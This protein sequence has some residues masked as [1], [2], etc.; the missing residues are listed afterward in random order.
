MYSK[1]ITT[2]STG[3]IWCHSIALSLWF[4]QLFDGR[5]AVSED[6]TFQMIN[7]GF[8]TKYAA[9]KGGVSKARD[10][11]VTIPVWSFQ[12]ICNF[13]KLEMARMVSKHNLCFVNE[14]HG[15]D[16]PA[17][18]A[19]CALIAHLLFKK[20]NKSQKNQM[21]FFLIRRRLMG[22]NNSTYIL[23]ALCFFLKRILD[24]G[25]FPVVKW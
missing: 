18:F 24:Y 13:S 14:K 11:G 4:S 15:F 12:P 19:H 10:L 17:W 3:P 8:H 2:A 9:L 1:G 23:P 20:E 25:A 5:V 21:G 22:S 7:D 6:L 16:D